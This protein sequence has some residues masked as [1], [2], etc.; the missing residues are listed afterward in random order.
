MNTEHQTTDVEI[1]PEGIRAPV[2]PGIARK[3]TT[4]LLTGPLNRNGRR[5][6]MEARGEVCLDPKYVGK[7]PVAGPAKLALKLE[8]LNFRQLT[9]RLRQFA[10]KASTAKHLAARLS[11]TSAFRPQLLASQNANLHAFQQTRAELN[12]RLTG[13][14]VSN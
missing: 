12:T 10:R 6:F 8:K 9:R 4:R 11:P 2:V 5:A 7:R 13:L 3:D 1:R 14:T